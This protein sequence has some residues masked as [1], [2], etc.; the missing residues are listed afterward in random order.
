MSNKILIILFLFF[1]S[2]LLFAQESRL[3][4]RL[5][6]SKTNSP[7]RGANIEV[8]G[9]EVE[10]NTNFLG[11]FELKGDSLEIEIS[12][13]N[14]D[15][16][17][18]RLT[19]QNPNV[20]I[21]LTSTIYQLQA[22]EI[23]DSQLVEEFVYNEENWKKENSD[24]IQNVQTDLAAF[25]GGLIEFHRYLI[26]E[27]FN[28]IDSLNGNVNSTITFSINES[29]ILEVDTIVDGSTN[30]AYLKQLFNNSPKWLAAF[31][32]NQPV[33]T[34]YEQQVVFT[35]KKEIFKLVDQQP[36]YSGGI[37]EFLQFVQ[38]NLK[39]PSLAKSKRIEGKVYV[40]FVVNGNGELEDIE[41]VKG[42]G[43]GC[44]REAERVVALTSGKW[45]PGSQE[46]R[47]VKV[48]M[49]FPIMFVRN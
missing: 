43:Y 13:I 11:Y 17:L 15:P 16:V 42:I 38:R 10:T 6:N 46:G 21:K 49:I 1:S 31:Q 39:Y 47:A 33:K 14:Y 35:P 40:S 28:D 30:T 27:F 4:G 22:L 2:N 41:T 9:T 18:V 12:H 3:M 36:E 25:P 44:D 34:S 29:G 19:K 45:I 8:R 24:R 26:G 37:G 32:N 23:M 7:V 48:R 5:I 20:L